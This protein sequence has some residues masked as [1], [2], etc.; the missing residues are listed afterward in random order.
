MSEDFTGRAKILITQRS[1]QEA[2]R[3]CRRGLLTRPDYVDGRILLGLALLALRRF[4]EVRVEMLALLR[5]APQHPIAHRIL[6]E[7]YLRAGDV[8]RAR[9]AL[10]TAAAL[11]PH[12]PVTQDL[13]EELAES[14]SA[15]ARSTTVERWLDPDALATLQ[16]DPPEF[17][18]VTMRDHELAPLDERSLPQLQTLLVEP[19]TE[20][21]RKKGEPGASVRADPYAQTAYASLDPE[22]VRKAIAMADDESVVASLPPAP[23]GVAQAQPARP[24]VRPLPSAA[25]TP[26]RAPPPHRG[27]TAPHGVPVPVGLLS[28]PLAGPPAPSPVVIVSPVAPPPR[29]AMHDPLAPRA[30]GA[31]PG[32]GAPAPRALSAL[33]APVPLPT[34]HRE[35]EPAP[36]LPPAE[37][38]HSPWPSAAAS[39]VAPPPK[40]RM[41]VRKPQQRTD[42]DGEFSEETMLEG[43]EA[44]DAQWLMQGA[45]SKSHTVA[46]SPSARRKDGEPDAHGHHELPPFADEESLTGDIGPRGVLETGELEPRPPAPPPKP[47]MPP[48]A[49]PPSAPPMGPPPARPRSEAPAAARP[50]ARAAPAGARPMTAPVARSAGP[51]PRGAAGGS[52]RGGAQGPRALAPQPSVLVS[53]ELTSGDLVLEQ[54]AE[55]VLPTIKRPDPAPVPPSPLPPSRDKAGKPRS[56]APPAVDPIAARR[57]MPSAPAGMAPRAGADAAMAPSR[58]GAPPRAAAARRLDPTYVPSRRS[59]IPVAVI[60]VG[61][62]AAIGLGVGSVLGV[63]AMGHRKAL[64]S[65]LV[66]VNEADK[67]GTKAAIERALASLEKLDDEP[68]RAARAR[69]LATLAL[70]HGARDVAD[71]SHR[72][73]SELEPEARRTDDAVL[74][75]ALLALVRSNSQQATDLI[76]GMRDTSPRWAEATRLSALVDLLAGDLN[77]ARRGADLA[78]NAQP[79][80]PRHESLAAVVQAFGGETDVALA[81]LARIPDHTSYPAVRIAR[82]RINLFSGRNPSDASAEAQAVLEGPL[83]AVAS[84]P[85]RAWA[86][87]VRAWFATNPSDRTRAELEGEVQSNPEALALVRRARDERP[88]VDEHFRLVAAEVLLRLGHAQEAQSELNAAGRSNVTGGFLEQRRAT[89]LV[90]AALAE[91]NRSVAEAALARLPPTDGTTAFLRGRLEE[92]RLQ[93]VE[94]RRHYAEAAQRDLRLAEIATLRVATIDIANGNIDAAHQSLRQLI[95]RAEGG[96][97]ITVRPGVPLASMLVRTHVA[98]GELAEAEQVLASARQAAPGDPRLAVAEAELLY[99]RGHERWADA[100]RVLEAAVRDRPDDIGLLVAQ[101]D[102]ARR[103]GDVARARRVFDDVLQRIPDQPDALLGIAALES[104][105]T[106]LAQAEEVLGRAERARA[107]PARLELERARYEVAQGNGGSALPALLRVAARSRLDPDVLTLLGRAYLQA[108]QRDEARTRFTAALRLDPASP[109]ALLGLVYINPIGRSSVPGLLRRAEQSGTSRALGPYFQCRLHAA[110]ARWDFEWAPSLQSMNEALDRATS[111][112]EQC[113][114]AHAVRAVRAADSGSDAS[115]HWRAAT[116]SPAPMARALAEAAE[117]LAESEPAQACALAA[118]YLLVAPNG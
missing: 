41:H 102:I 106:R 25:A 110:R 72:A 5:V 75:Q 24:L 48:S 117:S 88:L 20:S 78:A 4:E 108:E 34:P 19:P 96:R 89:L 104:S 101:G 67:K 2:V 15:P 118:R 58:A 51:A 62:L 57:P 114:E 8:Q 105:G 35:P 71:T 49:R 84:P 31:P 81:R 107:T 43:L 6:G 55:V 85:E 23:Q 115:E 17:W 73:W 50:A 61:A 65:A 111:A 100:S 18:E 36:V 3:I 79:Q 16:T 54:S 9:E 14:G 27:P 10:D 99:A 60:I 33:P 103:T 40:K 109:E 97:Q 52:P 113:G 69:L 59:K 116:R 32:A 82:A 21:S 46:G 83:A 44:D 26:P 93:P 87:L 37:P 22:E 64:D 95:V 90:L 29:G 30:P 76:S 42:E 91:G 66:E 77:G 53:E 94:A 56:H 1:Y 11:A 92:T 70:E 112:F 13:Q 38:I 12:D 39:P 98:R 28:P 68:A 63:R 74:A 86:R 7:A 47:A 80:S 45:D